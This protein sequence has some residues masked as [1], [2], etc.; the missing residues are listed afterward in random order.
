MNTGPSVADLKVRIQRTLDH[1]P[2][3]LPERYAIAWSA[4]LAA[5]VEWGLLSVADHADL[6]R[7][8][9]YIDDD[10]TAS[11]MLGSEG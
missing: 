5:L 8:L 10:P 4:Y 7:M 6:C 2:D 1:F 3:E 9:P 11:V